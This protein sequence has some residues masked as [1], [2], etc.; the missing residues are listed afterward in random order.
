M[1]SSTSLTPTMRAAAVQYAAGHQ[2]RRAGIDKRPAPLTDRPSL[3]CTFYSFAPTCCPGGLVRDNLAPGDEVL[4]TRRRDAKPEFDGR[5]HL[6][7]GKL[8]AG[9]SVL[10]AAIRETEEEVG[11]LIDPPACG[12]AA[13]TPSGADGASTR[14]RSRAMDGNV[15]RVLCWIGNTGLPVC[16]RSLAR[17]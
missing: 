4:R 6:P 7:S 1:I 8:D 16:P 15:A 5:W 17:R 14:R 2:P 10:H 11:V 13:S 9:E 12:R 3:T